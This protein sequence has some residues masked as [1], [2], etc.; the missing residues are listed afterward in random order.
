[1][2]AVTVRPLSP[3][4]SLMD[5]PDSNP[6]TIPPALLAEI[7]AEARKEHRPALEDAMHGYLRQKQRER[8]AFRTEDL[9][10]AEIA[11][12]VGGQMDPR[13]NHLDAE[14]E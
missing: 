12:I 2:V 14:L 7:E 6:L 8:R 4:L 1:M 10:E 3:M 11:A 5:A 9:S 13:H